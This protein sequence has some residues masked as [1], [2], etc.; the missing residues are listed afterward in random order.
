MTDILIP[1]LR[2]PIGDGALKY[3]PVSGKYPA[4]WFVTETCAVTGKA[5]GGPAFGSCAH[6]HGEG[7]YYGLICINPIWVEHEA[8]LAHEYAHLLDAPLRRRMPHGPGFRRILA[9]LGFPDE[10]EVYVG[11]DQ[12]ERADR[13]AR[14]AA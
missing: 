5:P 1:P 14:A 8:T 3:G 2:R 9:D 13:K 6:A 10:A 11:W 7:I 12:W 4:V